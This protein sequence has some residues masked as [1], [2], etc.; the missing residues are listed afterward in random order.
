MMLSD[1]VIIVEISD[2][3]TGLF[4]VDP[5]LLPLTFIKTNSISHG[6]K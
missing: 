3:L 4:M 1:M 2:M 6:L 5:R